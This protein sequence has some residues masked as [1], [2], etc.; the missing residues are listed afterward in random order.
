MHTI[1]QA[2]PVCG[3]PDHTDH[4]GLEWEH[5]G[6]IAGGHEFINISRLAVC[7]Q[8]ISTPNS[9]LTQA[10]TK[11]QPSNHD[12][13]HTTSPRER[14]IRPRGRARPDTGSSPPGVTHTV[15]LL[16]ESTTQI[17]PMIERITNRKHCPKEAYL[18]RMTQALII[19]RSTYA[20]PY[21]NLMKMDEERLDVIIRKSFKIVL[22]V[23]FY[24]CTDTF[25]N[26]LTRDYTTHSA[27]WPMPKF[28]TKQ[29]LA[30]T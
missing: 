26:F 14:K 7:S 3:R 15:H 22:E 28:K 2:L 16:L 25:L 29:R 24:A 8:I 4:L 17:M 1:H 5:A 27:N 19:S 23:P 9:T 13:G 6:L 11:V 10:G 21:L 18:I 20:A 30:T 12:D